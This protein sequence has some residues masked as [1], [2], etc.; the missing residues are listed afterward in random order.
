ME[1]QEQA[2]SSENIH[3]DKP[4]SLTYRFL[5]YYLPLNGVHYILLSQLVPTN[6]GM[7]FDVR[8]IVLIIFTLLIILFIPGCRDNPPNLVNSPADVTG[9]IIGALSGTPSERLA[10]ELGDART[11][12]S[13]DELMA[14]LKAGTIDCAVMEN[15]AA[16]ELVGDSSSVRILSEP[17]I[18]YDLHFAVAKENTELLATIN[19]AL[20]TL[21]QNG[22]L[23][24][25]IGKYFAGKSY[26]YKP[27]EG[28]ETHPGRLLLAVPPDSP[29]FSYLNIEGV[30]SGFDIDVAL[31][32]CDILGVELQIIEYDAWE[33]VNAVWFG[34]AD[35]ALGWLPGEGEDL[36][37][38]SDAY[39]NAVHVVIV[40]R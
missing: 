1:S 5:L 21:R 29:P 18:E 38:I 10:S 8:K 30:F 28:V 12:A 31:A 2:I 9:R 27:P 11:F 17:L 6:T 23:N 15:S 16:I 36:V 7:E 32:V 13:G 22:T 20:V 40:R 14:H 24:G 34:L 26:V 37:D 33:L 19:S 35:I 4:V 39:A 3:S 25:L